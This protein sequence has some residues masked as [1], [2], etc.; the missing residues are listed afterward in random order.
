MQHMLKQFYPIAKNILML[1]NKNSSS[2]VPGGSVMINYEVTGEG[3]Q[4]GA[5]FSQRK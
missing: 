1:I 5:Y 2:K 3:E 4:N